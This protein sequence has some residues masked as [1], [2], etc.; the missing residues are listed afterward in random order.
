MQHLLRNPVL[1][2][3]AIRSDVLILQHSGPR[4]PRRY[5]SPAAK[6]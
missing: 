6:A 4:I 1:R 2:H 3:V 5:P